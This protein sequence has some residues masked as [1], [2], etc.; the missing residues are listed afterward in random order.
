MA[1]AFFKIIEQREEDEQ[2]TCNYLSDEEI[3]IIERVFEEVLPPS[4]KD[5]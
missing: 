2:P 1:D 3:Q 4:L 5:N